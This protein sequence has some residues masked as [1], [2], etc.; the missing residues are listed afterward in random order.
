MK[1]SDCLPTSCWVKVFHAVLAASGPQAGNTVD[2]AH[3]RRV[4]VFFENKANVGEE[5]KSVNMFWGPGMI[6]H[7]ECFRNKRKKTEIK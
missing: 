2:P 6:T 7:A 4:H 3:R 1:L 5:K